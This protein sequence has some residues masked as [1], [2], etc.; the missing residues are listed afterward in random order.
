LRFWEVIKRCNFFLTI[1]KNIVIRMEREGGKQMIFYQ[2][3]GVLLLVHED[4]S[5][6]GGGGG[7]STFAFLSE[8]RIMAKLGLEP[9][10]YLTA[11][12]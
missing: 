4:G 6:C 2:T 8:S 12:V 7:G 3:S 1:E 9:F 5:T 11:T 10:Y